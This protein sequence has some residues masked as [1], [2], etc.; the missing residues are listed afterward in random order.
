MLAC[1]FRHLKD[2]YISLFMIYCIYGVLLNVC[3]L[4]MLCILSLYE[5]ENI[6]I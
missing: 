2:V 4:S 6:L 1:G 3:K 5:D